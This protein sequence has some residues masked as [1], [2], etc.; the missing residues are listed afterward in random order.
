MKMRLQNVFF[1]GAEIDAQALRRQLRIAS[2]RLSYSPEHQLLTLS[3]KGGLDLLRVTCAY[4]SARRFAKDFGFPD[5]ESPTRTSW[6]IAFSSICLYHNGSGDAELLRA[7]L[8]KSGLPYNMVS[9]SADL[10]LATGSGRFALP[11]YKIQDL[12][13]IVEQVKRSD[14]DLLALWK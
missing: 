12:V 8:D 14:A 6:M 11:M 9:G 2:Y 13:G 1:A 5:D 3:T 4:E 7:M 10:A